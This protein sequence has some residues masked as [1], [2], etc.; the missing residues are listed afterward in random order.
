MAA[1]AKAHIQ[2]L[3]RLH[4]IHF[5]HRT[6][7]CLAGYFFVN[8]NPVAESYK[9]GQNVN[10]VPA[11]LER[12]L[13]AIRPWPRDWLY[14]PPI[15]RSVTAFASFNRRNSGEVGDARI[16]VAVLTWNMMLSRMY[17]MAERYRL[18]QVPLRQPGALRKY[19]DCQ[20][21]N[22]SGGWQSQQQKAS[23]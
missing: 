13:A 20:A 3:D 15:E 11:N 17:T 18:A 22:E 8:M 23:H 12:R 7:T 14:F 1:D 16:G 10:A 21:R 4:S 2:V 9:R 19:R 5:L 6:M